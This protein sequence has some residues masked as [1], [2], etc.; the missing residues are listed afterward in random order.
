MR[1]KEID[2]VIENKVHNNKSYSNI[3]TDFIKLIIVL[4]KHS[5]CYNS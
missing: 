4:N 3:E 1:D 5:Y 2:T